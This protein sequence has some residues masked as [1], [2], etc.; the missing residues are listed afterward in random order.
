MTDA[1]KEFAEKLAA[2]KTSYVNDALPEQLQ[3]LHRCLEQLQQAGVEKDA[4][5]EMIVALHAASHKLAGSS[6]TFGFAELSVAARTLSDFTDKN[7]P[8]NA[9]NYHEH[10]EQIK[11]MAGKIKLARAA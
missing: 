7:S 2:I 5:G 9:T 1:N 8:L 6:G 10:L 4:A 3:N 11:E